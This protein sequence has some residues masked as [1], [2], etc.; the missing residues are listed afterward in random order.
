MGVKPAL[1]D[2]VEKQ[3]AAW[4]IIARMERTETSET[5]AGEGILVELRNVIQV[6]QES[7]A[8][9]T[10]AETSLAALRAGAHWG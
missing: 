7:R 2:V 8:E 1:E 4:R 9:A 10:Q 5:E 3:R 6:S